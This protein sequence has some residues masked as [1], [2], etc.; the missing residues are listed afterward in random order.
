MMMDGHAAVVT[1]ANHGIGAATAVELGRR[2][3]AVLCTFL[4]VHDEVDPAVPQ[5]YRDHRAAGAD[6]VVDQIQAA[7]GRALAVEADLSVPATPA[8]LF[9]LAEERFGPVDVLVNN[10]TGWVPDTFTP[11]GADRLRPARP[12]APTIPRPP[13]S[14]RPCCSPLPPAGTSPAARHG[15]GSSGS[16]PAETSASPK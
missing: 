2:G 14:P 3:C 1:G 12:P 15:A 5:A 16:P 7:G 9:D 13:P 4:R 8:V 11:A 10:A 6:A